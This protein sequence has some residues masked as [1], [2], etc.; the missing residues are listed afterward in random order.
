MMKY[1]IKQ[2]KIT[3]NDFW[4]I[5]FKNGREIARSGQRYIVVDIIASTVKYQMTDKNKIEIK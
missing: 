2:E 4:Y 3:E 1:E 5:L